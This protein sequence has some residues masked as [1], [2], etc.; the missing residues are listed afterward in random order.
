MLSQLAREDPDLYRGI[1]ALPWGSTIASVAR[2]VALAA[3]GELD[4]LP[5]VLLSGS[6]LARDGGATV[7]DVERDEYNMYAFASEVHDRLEEGR[8]SQ[9]EYLEVL[10]VAHALTAL[11][12]SI[13]AH[14]PDA[15]AA[16]VYEAR[17]AGLTQAQILAIVDQQQ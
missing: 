15:L 3:F 5:D 8:A 10:L 4:D 9:N 11:K 7:E 6:E 1:I 2:A 12:Y 13:A 14:D 16:V 17:R